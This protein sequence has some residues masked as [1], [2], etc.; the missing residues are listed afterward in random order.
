V[1]IQDIIRELRQQQA[2]AVTDR[3]ETDADVLNEAVAALI[4]CRDRHGNRSGSAVDVTMYVGPPPRPEIR[5]VLVPDPQR[6][7]R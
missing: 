5:F 3:R 7:L 4:R 2:Q 1:T 6:V